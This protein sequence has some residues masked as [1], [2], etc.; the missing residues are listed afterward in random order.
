MMNET[1]AFRYSGWMGRPVIVC[2]LVLGLLLL[3]GA[4]RAEEETA[5]PVQPQSEA[6]RP[7][8]I[9]T[10]DVSWSKLVT[11]GTAT[12]EI[13][14]GALPDGKKV[15]RFI[16]TT[17]SAGLVDTF[18]RVNDRLE[19]VFDPGTMQSLKLS[20]NA[21]HGKKKRRRELVFDHVNQTVISTLNDDPPETIVIP[22]Q[23]QDSLSSLYY[24]RT[25][26]NLIVGTSIYI[27]VHDSGKN[28][29]VEVQILGR[30]KVK[31]PAGEFATIKVRT[32]PKYEG[33]FMNKGEIFIWLTDD[34][35]RIPVLMKSTIAIGSLVSTLRSMEQGKAISGL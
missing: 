8:E 20:L 22:D 21:S 33:V 25:R 12:M 10:Y 31:T 6:L 13:K 18:Y 3:P 27:E 7:G 16:V 11:A 32:F 24:L 23:V 30:E 35:R 29:S 9:L 4:L 15:L 14:E 34:S 2:S 1:N 5:V 28:W 26:D 17:R 19:S